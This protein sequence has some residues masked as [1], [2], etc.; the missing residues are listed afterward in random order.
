MIENEQ[1]H[2]IKY[3]QL[4]QPR[5]LLF[6]SN[7]SHGVTQIKGE[8]T[9]QSTVPPDHVPRTS[10]QKRATRCLDLNPT[11]TSFSCFRADEVFD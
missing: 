1:T 4:S 7:S 9:W 11:F 2:R 10:I 8:G 6:M 5:Q 3:V